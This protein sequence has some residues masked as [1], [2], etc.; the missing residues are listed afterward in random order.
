MDS[1]GLSYRR[2]RGHRHVGGRRLPAAIVTTVAATAL[3]TADPLQAAA[4]VHTARSP[5]AT[6]LAPPAVAAAALAHGAQIRLAP[7]DTLPT[8]PWWDGRCDVGNDPRSFE[9]PAR[10]DGLADC[11]P[12]TPQHS[13][14]L[15]NFFPGAWGEL[16]W[17]CVEL[18]MRWM[19]M[20]WGVD[21][22]PA[23]GNG[24]VPNYPNGTAGYPRLSVVKNGTIGRAPQP[25]DVLS[26]DN[27]N[28]DGHTEVVASSSVDGAGNGTLTVITENDPPGASGWGALSVSHWVVSDGDAHDHVIGWLHNPNWTLEQPLLWEV[29]P[30]GELEIK[31]S[32]G[33]GGPFVSIASGIAT[34]QVAGGGG[35]GPAPVVVALTTS[36]VL[37]GGS[38]LPGGGVQLWPIASGVSSF[39]VSAGAGPSGHTVLAW[40]T[41]A[42]DLEVAAGG[43]HSTPV[44]E[45]RGAA[46][47]QLAPGSGP[48]GAVIGFRS[49]G[50]TFYDRAGVNALRAGSPWHVVARGVTSIA[51]AGGDEPADDVVEAY[52]RAGHFFARQGMGGPFTSEA[53]RVSA[54]AVATV[55]THA[56]PLL[57]FV[58]GGK[59]ESEL[60][61]ITSAA[62]A[63]QAS[64]VTAVSLAAGATAAAFPILGALT[65]RGFVTEDGT[66]NRQWTM[67]A[68]SQ[69]SDAGVA[70]LTVS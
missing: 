27:S 20:A 17:E 43:L 29:T 51:L 4:A 58:S 7:N 10:F 12:G 52:T 23:N 47:V 36:G 44:E 18:S 38:Y 63:L 30:S 66:L 22:Y 25:G 6:R 8:P 11:G 61:S 3:L 41:E 49:R 45:A 59:L 48:S 26:I 68:R 39:S 14:F 21:P 60:G 5:A 42:G 1:H 69:S 53:S 46:T 35:Y 56:E 13:D 37:V 9:L 70:A 67:E 50:G 55:G 28:P 40:V 32:G 64:G 31:D 16:E 62:F 54:M 65:S 19:Y 24:V 15:V 33:L 34:A 2:R 57:A